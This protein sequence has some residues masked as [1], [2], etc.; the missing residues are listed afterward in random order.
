MNNHTATIQT[1]KP[2]QIILA[3][4]DC[5]PNQATGTKENLECR[6]WYLDTNQQFCPRCNVG[7]ES[8]FDS[9]ADWSI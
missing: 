7:E 1:T 8:M 3:Y 6:G 9:F 2:P 5:C 4:C